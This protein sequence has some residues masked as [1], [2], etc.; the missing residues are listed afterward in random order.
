MSFIMTKRN[1]LNK[2]VE[3]NKIKTSKFQYFSDN[4]ITSKLSIFFYLLIFKRIQV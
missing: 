1:F 2:H 4:F 3:K